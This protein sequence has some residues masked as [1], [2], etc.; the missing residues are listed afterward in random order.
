MTITLIQS[1][2]L[3]ATGSSDPKDHVIPHALAPI[4]DFNIHVP[5]FSNQTAG[6]WFTNHLLML[7]VSAVLMLLMF[8]AVGRRYKTSFA[9]VPVTD[10]VPRGFTSLIEGFMDALR[11]GVVKPVLGG[12]T[13][14]F[15][16]F[17][18]TLFFFILINNLLGL[19]PFGAIF[20]LTMGVKHLG[21]TATGNINVTAGLALC[22]FFTIHVMGI[23]EV[24]TALMNGAFGHHHDEDGDHDAHHGGGMSGGA[25]SIASI[26]FYIWNFAPHVFT[27]EGRTQ[28][29]SMVLRVVM[30]AVYIP[31]LAAEFW[32]LGNMFGGAPL[33]AVFL[34]VGVGLGVVY[35]LIA[36]GL[37]PLDFADA[38]M[39]CFLFLLE[40]IGALVKPFA[41]CMRLFAN[42]IA[43]HIVL[44]SIIILIP[45]FTGITA[46]WLGTSL[47]VV[48]GCVALSCL[49]LFVA[50][51]QAY[52]FMFLTTMFIGAS[53]HPEH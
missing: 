43:G 14:R 15:M 40:V 18:W 30:L 44:A 20:E 31:L 25:A 52:I 48:V 9:G 13:D 12:D 7:L 39:W 45:L 21:G 3:A 50:F 28:K 36:G 6:F 38:L 23:L 26:A 32:L 37:H 8:S 16:P 4:F 17:L 22:A 11:T 34:W 24:R 51:L 2:M 49:E 5:L 10:S 33:A 41:L 42:M 35:A 27:K 29:P 1:L 53:I 19:I 46:A 47:I